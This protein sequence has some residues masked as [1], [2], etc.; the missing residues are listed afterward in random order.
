MEVVTKSII[1]E[2]EEVCL[3]GIFRGT[4]NPQRVLVLVPAL[5]GTRIGPQRIF[6]EISNELNKQKI[7]TICFDFS[8]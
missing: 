1:I 6:V 8:C 5:T 4:E 7:S 3:Y 2:D